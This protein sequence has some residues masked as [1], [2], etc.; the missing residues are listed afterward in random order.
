MKSWNGS[1]QQVLI[2]LNLNLL[3]SQNFDMSVESVNFTDSL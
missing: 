3:E 1:R 2:L